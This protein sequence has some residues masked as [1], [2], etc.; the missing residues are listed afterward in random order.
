LRT[1]AAHT[2]SYVTF[3]YVRDT[4]IQATHL[5]CNCTLLL[6]I[7]TFMCL[8]WASAFAS[9]RELQ[10]PVSRGETL[11]PERLWHRE[12]IAGI[13]IVGAIARVQAGGS[14]SANSYSDNGT[15]YGRLQL[16]RRRMR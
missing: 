7:A 14:L 1:A 2:H 4:N 12:D 15:E 9:A 10:S 3:I 8:L 16:Q 5:N 6:R 13:G 11:V